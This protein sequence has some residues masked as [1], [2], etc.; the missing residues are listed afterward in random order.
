[1]GLPAV[2]GPTAVPFFSMLYNKILHP[3]TRSLP[4]PED[5][6]FPFKQTTNA[7][8]DDDQNTLYPGL[9]GQFSNRQSVLIHQKNN[10]YH[11]CAIS[12]QYINMCTKPLNAKRASDKV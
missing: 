2:E 4:D 12:M 9:F 10:T 7:A 3:I 11:A 5:V 8:E 6:T 1:M